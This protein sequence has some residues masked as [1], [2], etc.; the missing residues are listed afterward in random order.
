MSETLSPIEVLRAQARA[1]QQKSQNRVSSTVVR[2]FIVNF[3]NGSDDYVENVETKLFHGAKAAAAVNRLRTVIKEDG[4]NEL[5]WAIPT[6]N[7]ATLV[8]LT[9]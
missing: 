4:L 9:D 7:G 8:K 1:N 5:V 3:L 6:D 2:T